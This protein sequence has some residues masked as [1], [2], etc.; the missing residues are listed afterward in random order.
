MK[1]GSLLLLSLYKQAL[2][3]YLPISCRYEP[4]CSE[5]SSGA[6]L[7][8]GFIKGLWLS[9]ARLSRCR[10]MGGNGYDPIP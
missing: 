10:P 5:Y 1:N 2:S 6:I 4:T 7:K 9:I 8:H 3:P